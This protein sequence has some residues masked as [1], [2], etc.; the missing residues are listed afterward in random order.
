M[1][2]TMSSVNSSAKFNEKLKQDIYMRHSSLICLYYQ[3]TFYV[4]I[5]FST[6]CYLISLHF[7]CWK[8]ADRSEVKIT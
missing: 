2:I 8:N 4:I 7:S 1:A 3:N 5:K 6:E